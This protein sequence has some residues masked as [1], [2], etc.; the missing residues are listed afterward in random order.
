VEQFEAAHAIGTKARLALALLLYTG[1][2][3]SDVHLFGPQHVSNGLLRFTQQKNAGRKPVRL[4]LPLLPVLQEVIAASPI[5]TMT[6]L[7]PNTAG[8]S[9][10]RASASGFASSAT[11]LGCTTVQPMACVRPGPRSRLRTEQQRTSS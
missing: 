6:Y 3:G 5:G 1:Q 9:R 8:R 7:S 2:R 10:E 11:E 4:Q